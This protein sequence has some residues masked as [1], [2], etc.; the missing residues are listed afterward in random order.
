MRV[1]PAPSRWRNAACRRAG[2]FRRDRRG[3]AAVEFAIVG[4][5]AIE[6]VLETMQV[7]YYFYTSAS[8]E[9]ATNKATRQIMTGAVSAAGYTAAQFRSNVLCPLLPGA[10]ACGSVVTNIQS[11][12]ED[13]APNG[14]YAFVNASQSAVV[15]PT[16]NNAQTT[17]CSGSTGSVIYAQVYYAMPVFSPAWRALAT[18]WNGNPVHFVTAASAFKNEPF[19]GGT[20]C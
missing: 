2:G 15:M 11:V 8:L 16:M 6:F 3:S 1:R 12:S 13:V 17:F 20:G 4:L 5:L 10:M 14:F 18:T 9:S 7:G 19:Q